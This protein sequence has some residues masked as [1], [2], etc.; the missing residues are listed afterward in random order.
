M[1]SSMEQLRARMYEAFS[2]LGFFIFD[3]N[4]HGLVSKLLRDLTL[5]RVLKVRTLSRD[6]PYMIVEIDT[7][8]Y[9]MECRHKCTHDH[10]FDQKC[11]ALCKESKELEILKNVLNKL[12]KVPA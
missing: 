11:Y 6:S 10:I 1:A 4:D 8:T 7:R 9:A 2:K 5:H 3:K 12:E